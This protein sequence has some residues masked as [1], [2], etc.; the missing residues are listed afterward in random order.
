M[1][2]YEVHEY[3]DLITSYNKTFNPNVYKKMVQ[4][5]P[6]SEEDLRNL[7]K[8]FNVK[9]P[10]AF[11]ESYKINNTSFGD[12]PFGKSRAFLSISEIVQFSELYRVRWTES[13]DDEC[14]EDDPDCP[15]VIK[16]EDIVQSSVMWPQE[17]V[18]FGELHDFL[19]LIL[20]MREEMD[21]LK[22]CVLVFDADDGELSLGYPDFE[23]CL[24]DE[25]KR[26]LETSQF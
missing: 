16:S 11:K 23:S 13:K 24:A 1:D 18:K 7:E 8:Y 26:L 19:F 12:S 4:T 10:S 5:P 22:G 21:S 25:T 3:W 2:T 9:L 15:F 6:A 14:D 17:W 20:D